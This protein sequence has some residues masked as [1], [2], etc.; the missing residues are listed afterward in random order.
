MRL[1][2]YSII[3]QRPALQPVLMARAL[4]NSLCP[5]G[6]ALS[7]PLCWKAAGELPDSGS[8]N[9]S[10]RSPCSGRPA[11]SR[12]SSHRK[13][14][15]RGWAAGCWSGSQG[16]EEE[17]DDHACCQYVLEERSEHPLPQAPWVYRGRQPC[18]CR[19]EIRGTVRGALD[20]ESN[21]LRIEQADFG[22]PGTPDPVRLLIPVAHAACEK[23][24]LI[25][26]TPTGKS[27]CS[28]RNNYNNG[29]DAGF[30]FINVSCGNLIRI[31]SKQT[32]L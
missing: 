15:V 11:R 26:A 2:G 17:G 20:A 12:T 22:R 28:A 21:G 25:A 30:L 31:I 6:K 19:G 1:C 7:L 24:V 9:R 8:W 18:R 5:W 23:R 10:S 29:S 16:C 14:Q 32:Y 27:A 4:R 13:R 3:T